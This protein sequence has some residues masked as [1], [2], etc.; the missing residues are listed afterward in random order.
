MKSVPADYALC[1]GQIDNIIFEIGLP[2]K[3][4]SRVEMAGRVK[5][6]T[7]QE[8]S[9]AW[10]KTAYALCIGIFVPIGVRLKLEFPLFSISCLVAGM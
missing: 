10:T 6:R 4:R 8:I 7:E 3:I 1:P 5:L 9:L 2:E